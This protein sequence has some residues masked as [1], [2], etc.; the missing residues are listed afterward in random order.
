MNQVIARIW[1]NARP[2]KV[3]TL[4]WLTLNQGLP[5]GTWLQPMGI[6]PICKVCNTNQ[7][8]SP[9][10]CL[11]ECPKAQ[12]AWD[13]FKEVWKEWQASADVNISWPFVLLGEA[14]NEREEDPPDLFAYHKGGFSYLRQPLD[15]LRSLLLYYLWTGRCR[16]NFDDQ[17]SL[18]QVLTQ[19][20]VAMVEV[21]MATWKAIRARKA[22][23]D[24]DIQ[25]RIEL[26]FRKEW[27]HMN[28]LGK[29][30]ATIWWHFLPPLYFT[31]FS[32]D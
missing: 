30:D 15:I 29:D 7:V 31:N 1:H 2:K 22:T 24:P 12:R 16:K 8:K 17:Y 19:A 20:W 5:V 21:G 26:D 27:L 11:L 18:K 23:K 25:S 9:T 6:D 3:E 14:V 4:I 10:H 32:N 28:I 13:A